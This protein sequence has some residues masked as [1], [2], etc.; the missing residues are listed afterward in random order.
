MSN[1]KFK[2]KLADLNQ[3]MSDYRDLNAEEL[4]ELKSQF[5]TKTAKKFTSCH[6][7]PFFECKKRTKGK[8]E[9]ECIVAEICE[10]VQVDCDDCDEYCKKFNTNHHCWFV[11]KTYKVM[12]PKKKKYF[13]R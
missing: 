7:C 2:R 9:A 10:L 3:Q 11:K 13:K 1:E 6:K 12:V 8:L 4:E 5:P